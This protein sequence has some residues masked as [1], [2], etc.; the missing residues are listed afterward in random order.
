MLTIYRNTVLMI[1]RTLETIKRFWDFLKSKVHGI[2]DIILDRIVVFLCRHYQGP[3]VYG[4][5]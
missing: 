4:N 1:L 2:I 5:Y 3:D